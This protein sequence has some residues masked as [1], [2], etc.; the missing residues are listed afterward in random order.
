MSAFEM[1]R[2]IE[3]QRQTLSQLKGGANAALRLGGLV[4]RMRLRINET[5]VA[6]SRSGDMLVRH[7]LGGNAF[8][9][10][11][12]FLPTR[13]F[14]SGATSSTDDFWRNFTLC[15]IPMARHFKSN[16]NLYFLAKI[17]AFA[18]PCAYGTPC[19]LKCDAMT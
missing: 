11:R 7:R 16:G 10:M 8:L 18:S 17:A 6:R 13:K 1:C 4:Q 15:R 3:I 2:T 12:G 9:L 19:K 5:F 14:T